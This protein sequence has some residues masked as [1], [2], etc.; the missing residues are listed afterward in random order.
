MRKVMLALVLTVISVGLAIFAAY[1]LFSRNVPTA[2]PQYLEGGQPEWHEIYC[3]R[4]YL[5]VPR[6]PSTDA[7]VVVAGRVMA[8]SKLALLSSVLIAP[9]THIQPP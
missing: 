8:M 7:I 5:W 2:C 6:P 4:A 3:G 1:S 9:P